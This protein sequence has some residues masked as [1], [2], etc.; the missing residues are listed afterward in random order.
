MNTYGS[1]RFVLNEILK[2]VTKPVL[3]LGA[4][5]HSTI[6]IDEALKDRKIV[7]TTIDDSKVWLS[8]YWKLESEK[9]KL[10]FKSISEIREFYKNDNTEYGL[11]FIDLGDWGLRAEAIN[12]YKDTADYII[13]HDCNYFPENGFFGT[14]T[15]LIN[16]RTYKPGIRNYDDVFKYWTEYFMEGWNRYS[17]PTLLGSNKIC[18]KKIVVEKMFISNES[19]V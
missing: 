13:L 11:V 7:I 18:L 10:L 6:Q 17:P 12:K 19:V 16:K 5:D 4:G 1:H 3:E 2:R 9:H 8:R 15:K 14:S